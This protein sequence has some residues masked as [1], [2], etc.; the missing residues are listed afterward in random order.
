MPKKK[1]TKARKN[2]SRY[3]L[4]GR[5]V[6]TRDEFFYG[7]KNYRKPGYENKGY[8]RKGLV[9]DSNRKDELVIVK[10][11]KPNQSLPIPGS[12]STY[13]PYVETKDDDGKP[14]KI[15]VKF[16]LNK[17]NS[18]T[19]ISKHG[20]SEVKKVVFRTSRNANRNRSAVRNV[21]GRNGAKKYTDRSPYKPKT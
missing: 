15:G 7:A 3:I 1:R 21:K 19:T 16:K 11:H 5:T 6:Q 14:I 13:K 8:Y 10:L 12:K 4:P 17:D 2:V 9:V 18:S 20:V